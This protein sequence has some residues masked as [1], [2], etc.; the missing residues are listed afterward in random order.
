M[1][2]TS[3]L[4]RQENNVLLSMPKELLFAVCSFLKYSECAGLTATCQIAA[5]LVLAGITNSC[6][7]N[8]HHEQMKFRPYKKPFKELS[9]KGY[10]FVP[11][12]PCKDDKGNQWIAYYFKI[13][14][15]KMFCCFTKDG[16]KR[17]D[18][19]TIGVCR[20][21]APDRY[22]DN[23]PFAR[24]MLINIGELANKSLKA[25]DSP[26]MMG[27]EDMRLLLS[28]CKAG[29][30]N[31]NVAI[32]KREFPNPE[33]DENLQ[34]AN[35]VLGKVSITFQI[36]LQRLLDNDC[37]RDGRRAARFMVWCITHCGHKKISFVYNCRNY[38][39]LCGRNYPCACIDALAEELTRENVKNL[40]LKN[41]ALQCVSIVTNGAVEAGR[42][43]EPV[44]KLVVDRE[45]FAPLSFIDIV[46]R[47]LLMVNRLFAQLCD[48]LFPP[49]C[50][51]YTKERKTPSGWIYI[52]RYVSGCLR[53]R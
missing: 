1:D 39:Y 16:W 21:L 19:P 36:Q 24:Y 41:K 47:V 12:N 37:F 17:L 50:V 23:P 48:A 27:S 51:T 11:E 3:P 33:Y 7:D 5:F 25:S 38:S 40:L 9:G 28:T 53:P 29:L 52:D 14:C 45:E 35:G 42:L 15:F 18:H 4:C 6:V 26:V 13:G 20:L 32:S 34:E 43:R 8:G 10:G 44:S 22:C 31:I 46:K 2:Y 49:N 30:I